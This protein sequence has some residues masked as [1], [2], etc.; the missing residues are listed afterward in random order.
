MNLLKKESS[1]Y[2]LQHADNPVD[3]H[4]WGET[5][6]KLAETK[7]QPILLS[8]GYSACHWCH[9]MAHESFEDAATAAIMNRQFVNIKVDREERPD[10]DRIYQTAHQLLTRRG[11]GWPLT[12]FLT[13]EDRIPFFAGTYF[14]REPRYGL[15]AFAELLTQVA[16]YYRE[17]RD[18]IC[19]Q[20]ND[21][22]TT[23]QTVN[24]PAEEQS[25]TL[26]AT[27]LDMA[28]QQLAHQYDES[29]GGFGEAPKFPH[30]MNLERLLHHWYAGR[31]RGQTDDKALN[32]ARH[33]LEKMAAGGLFDQLGGGFFRYAVDQGW[34]IPHFEKMLYDNAQLLPLYAQLDAIIGEARYTQIVNATLCWLKDE[35]AAPQGGYFA[36]LD[37]D[38]EGGEGY[39]Y[40]WTTAETLTI[41]DEDEAAVFSQRFGLDQD[42]NFESRWH[43]HEAM[44]I[45]EIAEQAG[46]D[47]RTV[48]TLLTTACSKL[49]KRREQRPRPAR[50][51]KII[52]AWNALCIRALAITSRHTGRQDCLADALRTL[53]FVHQNLWRE[54]RLLASCKDG[55]A[56]QAAYLDDYAFLLDAILETLQ[57]QWRT[58]DLRFAVELAD[59]LLTHFYDQEK[60]GF[61]FTANDHEPLFYRPRPFGD[62]ALPA[63]NGVAARAL[64]RLGHLLGEPRYLAAAE[65]TLS[66]AWSE[67]MA[68]PH[69]HNTLLSALE[70]SLQPPRIII[71]RGSGAQLARWQTRCLRPFAP[72]RLCFAIP[73]GARN[74]PGALSHYPSAGAEVQAFTCSGSQCRAPLRIF[75][76]LERLLME[77]EID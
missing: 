16:A 11:G 6:L 1:P 27:P 2:L 41:L 24:R 39:F 65:H 42:A 51:E 21:F 67:I 59:G 5:A 44:T 9:V 28:R 31:V 54:G 68:L 7:Q 8:I 63:G 13:P 77:E 32:M 47:T 23:L 40:T 25:G 43:L 75:A 20:N 46:Q 61:Y 33:S 52:T 30:P 37:A 17:H 72:H 57:V 76:D 71:L 15:P 18:E 53:E 74:L 50:D 66:A 69:G 38:S 35:M 34:M 10:L 62:E 19:R 4:P 55:K 56:Q 3:W 70:E 26:S 36:T 14:P 58:E 12:L 22:M 48:E 60:G 49:A 29:H 73:D 45:A 64:A